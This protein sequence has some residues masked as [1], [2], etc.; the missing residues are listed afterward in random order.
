MIG[1]NYEK[2][3]L[4]R[5]IES[6]K[7]E[8]VVVFGRRRVGKTFLVREF[9]K[10]NFTFYH[11]GMA[12]STKKQQLEAFNTSLGK[13]GN[14]EF[15]QSKDW[16][17]SFQQLE[18]LIIGSR[19][20][21]KKVIFIDEM[22]WLDTQRSDFVSALEY[23]W[24]SFASARKDVVFIACGSA[25]S[26][27]TNKILK[28]HGG[29]HNRVTRQIYIH[30][31]TL[32]ECEE[33]YA[34]QKI[35]MSHYEMVENYMILGGI[36]YYL[37]FIRKELSMAQNVNELLFKKQSPLFNEFENLYA[38]LF[39][40]AANHLKIVEALSKKSKGLTRDEILS[41]TK[42]ANGG[43]F[44]QTLND[45]E[46]C[47]FI[48]KYNS[49]SNKERNALF[50]LCDFYTL[51]YF[52]YL[53][54]NRF[55][56]EHF[57]TNLLESGQHRAW[58]GYSF[59]QVCLS[60]IKQIKQKLGISGILTKTAAWRSLDKENPAQIDLLIERNDNVINLCEMKFSKN[61]FVID[62]EYD[63]A[64]RNK[65]SAFQTASK[66]RK[67]IH[68]TMVTTYGVKRNIYSG[69]IQSEVMLNDLF[70]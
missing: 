55:D 14:S 23:F 30:P 52:Y 39:K 45:L 34:S 28:N 1:R 31:F 66:T 20:R 38:S 26:W 59:E 16:F 4:Q 40:N 41:A 65:R 33:Y 70:A 9:F 54:K 60:H 19:K 48:R 12:R 2:A 10:N 44:T 46:L 37:S 56:D 58:S 43:N 7:A 32:K 25:T 57:W 62:K 64:L 61:E 6:D 8:F 47:G 3:E 13:Y 49:F 29:L 11:T 18:K 68:I 15:A 63:K 36:P 53:Q 24:N 42:I 17:N 5:I 27:I 35:V 67:T 51:F 69:S 50:Q 22:P 21:G